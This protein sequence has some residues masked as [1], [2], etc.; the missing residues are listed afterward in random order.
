MRNPLTFVVGL[1]ILLIFGSISFLFQVRE[2][3]VAFLTTFGK[4]DEAV[5]K[6]GLRFKLP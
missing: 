4:A 1:V 6:P 3:E 2:S 5:I